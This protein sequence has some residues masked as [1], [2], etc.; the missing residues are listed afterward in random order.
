MASPRTVAGVFGAAMIFFAGASKPAAGAVANAADHAA[1]SAAH[2]AASAVTAAVGAIHGGGPYTP[3]S[4]A[5]ALLRA[6]GLPRTSCNVGAV[7]SWEA[8]EGGNWNNSAAYNP[9]NTTMP[10]PGSSTMN[11][12]GVRAYTSWRQGLRATIDTLN[13]GNYGPILDALRA[14]NDAQAV[15]DAEADTPWGTGPFT[16]HCL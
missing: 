5:R 7:M 3:Q 12:V 1:H 4:W 11:S 16:A 15:A 9:L 8:A 14:G 2:S 13:N 10:E 6:E